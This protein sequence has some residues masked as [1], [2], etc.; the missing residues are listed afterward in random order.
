MSIAIWCL[1]IIALLLL[2]ASLAVCAPVNSTEET[3]E[4]QILAFNDFHGQ[5]EPPSGSEILYYNTTNYPFE[6]ELGGASY[7]VSRQTS[8]VG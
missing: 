2:D 5:I 6:A 4:L 7:L 1:L 8:N 3:V